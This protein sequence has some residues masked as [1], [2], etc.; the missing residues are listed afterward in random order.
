MHN[1]IDG[2]MLLKTSQSTG[3]API[4][5][6][7]CASASWKQYRKALRISVTHILC[8][9]LYII[10][11]GEG[12]QKMKFNHYADEGVSCSR[13]IVQALHKMSRCTKAHNIMPFA[14][15]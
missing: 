6:V 11:V 5:T 10:V 2:Y 4:L 1:I 14:S 9:L 12:L 3:P 8:L 7:P 13:Y 15:G